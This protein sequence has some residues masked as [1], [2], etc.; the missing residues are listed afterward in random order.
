MAI[1]RREITSSDDGSNGHKADV[2]RPMWRLPRPRSGPRAW[3]V[4]PVQFVRVFV[5][6]Q[7]REARGI[8]ARLLRN[9]SIGQTGHHAQR[10]YGPFTALQGL[11]RSSLR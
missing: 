10:D 9:L 1:E 5:R 2:P 7:W 4:S 8:D 3:H 11:N 6:A